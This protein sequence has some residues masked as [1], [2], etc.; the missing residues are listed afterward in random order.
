MRGR[1]LKSGV[2]IGKAALKHKGVKQVARKTRTI[3][4]QL[5]V[6]AALPLGKKATMAAE[7]KAG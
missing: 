6:P 5:H 4:S 2:Y 1:K 7:R 3:S